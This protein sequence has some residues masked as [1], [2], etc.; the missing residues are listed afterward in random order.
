M[1]PVARTEGLVVRAI[2]DETLVYDTRRHRAHCLNRTAALVFRL[3]DGTRTVGEIA[4]AIGGGPDAQEPVAMALA[5]LTAAGLLASPPET[6]APAGTSRREAL[7][8]V[9]LGA[10][11]L[12]PIVTSLVVPTPAEA[13]ATCIPQAACT[14]E[15]FGQPCYTLSD[16]Q[17]DTYECKSGP[18]GVCGPI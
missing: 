13:A 10:A 9:G 18:P 14:D 8:R 2:G 3:S 15:K 1:R 16:A 12:A 17:C 7:R 5:Q 6:G 4:A 11:L